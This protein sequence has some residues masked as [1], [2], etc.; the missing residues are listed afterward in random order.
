MAIPTAFDGK[1][2][3][4]ENAASCVLIKL[5]TLHHAGGPDGDIAGL[6]ELLQAYVDQVM[7]LAKDGG[8]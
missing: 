1:L 8:R 7:A 6:R 4:I 2:A 3:E 5:R